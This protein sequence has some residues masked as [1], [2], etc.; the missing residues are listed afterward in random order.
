MSQLR[1]WEMAMPVFRSAL[2]EVGVGLGNVN[3]QVR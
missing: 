3:G 2:S 1:G